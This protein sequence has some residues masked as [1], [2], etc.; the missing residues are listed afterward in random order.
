ERSPLN[1]MRFS[2]S[3]DA[4]PHQKFPPQ[5]KGARPRESRSGI[6]LRISPDISISKR[7]SEY[8]MR[9][10][11]VSASAGNPPRTPP[12]AGRG[13]YPFRDP[14]SGASS[15]TGLAF[16]ERATGPELPGANPACRPR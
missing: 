5:T 15:R 11:G 1:D 10:R 16:G 9:N 7:G 6:R 2:G 12:E 13:S 8:G 4:Y 14:E 3:A